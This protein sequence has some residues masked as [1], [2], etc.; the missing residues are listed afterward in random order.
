MF[1]MLCTNVLG[2]H[3]LTFPKVLV[4]YMDIDILV[5]TGE[6]HIDSYVHKYSILMKT[7]YSL[8]IF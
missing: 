6:Y 4:V 5:I 3:R 1:I 2:T 7:D 8:A